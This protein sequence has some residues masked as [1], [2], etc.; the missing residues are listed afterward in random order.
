MHKD[1]LQEKWFKFVCVT[2]SFSVGPLSLLLA[3]WRLLRGFD[4][5]L[6]KF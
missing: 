3:L 2:P 5:Q 1:V 4:I 6:P